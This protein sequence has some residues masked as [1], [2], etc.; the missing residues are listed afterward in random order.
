MVVWTEQQKQTIRKIIANLISEENK[1]KGLR[2]LAPAMLPNEL[3]FEREVFKAIVEFVDND[4]APNYVNVKTYLENNNPLD[5]HEEVIRQFDALFSERTSDGL[6]E[7][8]SFI[9]ID[10]LFKNKTQLALGKINTI[11]ADPKLTSRDAYFEALEV[12]KGLAPRSNKERVLSFTE[13]QDKWFE[14]REANIALVRS[15]KTIGPRLPWES[16]WEILPYMSPNE[17]C[18]IYGVT[19]FGKSTLAQ[20]IAEDIAHVQGYDVLFVH[21]ETDPLKYMSRVLARELVCPVVPLET[22]FYDKNGQT[23]FLDLTRQELGRR[24][25]RIRRDFAHKDANIGTFYYNHCPGASVEDI[26]ASAERYQVLAAEK[27]RKL[28]VVI[29]YFQKLD[30]SAYRAPAKTQGLN[31]AALVIKNVA[32]SLGIN[33]IVFAQGSLED[34]FGQQDIAK[35]RDA[36]ELVVSSQTVIRVE[37]QIATSDAPAKHKEGVD[38]G[39]PIY[40]LLGNPMYAHRKGELDSIAL[41]RLVKGNNASTATEK[42]GKIRIMNGYFMVKSVGREQNEF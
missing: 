42:Q 25:E 24:V 35:L 27:G 2:D 8:L 31:Q 36:N 1:T 37:R 9:L 13:V 14:Q 33:I 19:G 3:S 32:E 15:G 34:G 4:I 23:Y 12:L 29:D 5:K 11:F 17:V 40:D 20:L 39:K 26:A 10:T 18:V 28:V 16:T 7:P 6:I 38:R 21:L 22:G 30:W 41:L